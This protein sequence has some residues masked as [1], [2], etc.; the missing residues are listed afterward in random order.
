[1][2]KMD[3]TKFSYRHHS[4]MV[5]VDGVEIPWLFLQF[6]TNLGAPSTVEV[7]VEP[8]ELIE[9]IRPKTYIHIFMSD[10]YNEDEP[11]EGRPDQEYERNS[12]F[13]KERYKL[14]FE[15]QI[16][17]IT[18]SESAESRSMVL[19]CSD[20]F[21]IINNTMLELVQLNPGIHI[22]LINGSTFYGSFTAPPGNSQILNYV[23]FA[24]MGFN[25][26]DT[27]PDTTNAEREEQLVSRASQQFP[28]LRDGRQSADEYFF[29][30]AVRLALKY[31][32][33][34]NAS[35]RLQA[36]RSRLFDKMFGIGDQTFQRF[37]ERRIAQTLITRGFENVPYA[38]LGQLMSF[39]LGVGLHN[40]TSMLFPVP[41]D[42]SKEGAWNQYL[43]LPNLYYAIAPPCNWVFPEHVQS[44]NATRFFHQEPTR[45]GVRDPM[46]GQFGLMHLAPGGLT[47]QLTGGN[48]PTDPNS[49]ARRSP[50]I[51]MGSN[52][53]VTVQPR[54]ERELDQISFRIQNEAENAITN[55]NLLRLMSP[56]EIEKGIVY[57]ISDIS[58][59]YFAGVHGATD[60]IDGDSEFRQE[61]PVKEKLDDEIQILIR[62]QSGYVEYAQ[63]LAEYRLTIEQLNRDVTI[64][65][66]FNP[67]VVAG[68]PVMVCRQDRSYRG[69]LASVNHTVGA[70]GEAQTVYNLAYTTLFQPKIGWLDN[71]PSGLKDISDQADRSRRASDK[72]QKTADALKEDLPE[73][74]LK[75]EPVDVEKEAR[76]QVEDLKSVAEAI[77]VLRTDTK[78][79]RKDANFIGLDTAMQRFRNNLPDQ[80]RSRTDKDLGEITNAIGLLRSINRDTR[81]LFASKEVQPKPLPYS[82]FLGGYNETHTTE[83]GSVISPQA[84][85]TYRPRVESYLRMV[86]H[87]FDYPPLPAGATEGTTTAGVTTAPGFES[88][89]VGEPTTLDAGTYRSQYENTRFTLY[90]TRSDSPSLTAPFK[91]LLRSPDDLAEMETIRNRFDEWLR[92]ILFLTGSGAVLSE[93]GNIFLFLGLE[94][95]VNQDAEVT[96]SEFQ[97]RWSLTRMEELVDGLIERAIRLVSGFSD[98]A[99]VD[100]YV[101]KLNPRI[102]ALSKDRERSDEERRKTRND[103]QNLND[104]VT[105]SVVETA[106][107]MPFANPNLLDPAKVEEEYERVLGRSELLS[108]VVPE[109]LSSA[110][111][112]AV[113]IDARLLQGI[114]TASFFRMAANIFNFDSTSE[115]QSLYDNWI[116]QGNAH[117]EINRFN[118]RAGALTL[119]EFLDRTDLT[120]YEETARFGPFSRTFYRMSS[121]AGLAVTVTTRSSYFDCLLGNNP[122]VVKGSEA[123][124]DVEQI[125][126]DVYFEANNPLLYEEARQDL[127][128]EYARRH[129]VPRAL[130]GK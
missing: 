41:N 33:Q 13:D 36:M 109:A 76:S 94:K 67:W 100:D 40:H 8:D 27:D 50:E 34:F 127:I 47:E 25:E 104:Q 101:A 70:S 90:Y 20:L 120:L 56:I 18:E 58:I 31:F 116:N 12:K 53:A 10:P 38:S 80:V 99:G 43:F 59:E 124:Q 118:R 97:V 49:S 103:L 66:P 69:L 52:P 44:L 122:K 73:K 2:A 113:D 60:V 64:A 11:E 51:L 126:E 81:H 24:A 6:R 102:D 22:P 91:D 57:R 95:D 86:D 77:R 87:I 37:M 72:A 4:F 15:G 23:I 125:R 85:S 65:G 9:R 55:P 35:Y 79:W 28:L 1:M 5:F 83:L 92:N 123:D 30:D 114:S 82:E 93:R 39:M 88:P 121:T 89:A 62:D 14:C 115:R 110:F 71:I 106:P 75:E 117:R 96:Q 119:R 61:E 130:R 29:F 128:L 42:E 68:F 32:I 108:S 19:S 84:V 78:S 45:I 111:Q 105:Q 26:I 7:Y 48:P 63:T 112:Q 74:T 17:G 21:P 107:I 98:A 129:F 3:R 46:V 54:G 16:Q